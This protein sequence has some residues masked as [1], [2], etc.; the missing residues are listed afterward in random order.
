[1]FAL[2]LANSDD[3]DEPNEKPVPHG[4]GKRQRNNNNHNNDFEPSYKRSREESQVE[5]IVSIERK[6]NLIER[7]FL[8]S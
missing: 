2:I 1:M 3:E 5:T 8:E 7:I 6:Q 4:G